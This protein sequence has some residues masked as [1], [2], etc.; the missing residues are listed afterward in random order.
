MSF[1]YCLSAL[2]ES[3]IKAHLQ[4][5]DVFIQFS[6]PSH[7]I[8]DVDMLLLLFSFSMQFLSVVRHKYLYVFLVFFVM[9]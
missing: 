6:K 7:N 1:G 3:N 5:S 2:I 9:Q 4:L 8:T